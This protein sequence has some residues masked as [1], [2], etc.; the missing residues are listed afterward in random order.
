MKC[1][2]VLIRVSRPPQWNLDATTDLQHP[3]PVLEP[4]EEQPAHGMPFAPTSPVRTLLRTSDRVYSRT[5]RGTTSHLSELA[6]EFVKVPFDDYGAC[7]EFI[8]GHPEIRHESLDNFSEEAIR[9]QCDGKT[10]QLRNCVEKLLLLREISKMSDGD[11][12][13]FFSRMKVKDSTTRMG[14]VGDFNKV[15]NAVQAKAA[16]RQTNLTNPNGRRTEPEFVS[17]GDSR[18]NQVLAGIRYTPEQSRYTDFDDSLSAPMNRLSVSTTE[19]D[20]SWSYGAGGNNTRPPPATRH[21]TT[22]RRDTLSSVNDD[23]P[24]NLFTNNQPE[25]GPPSIVERTFDFRGTGGDREALDHRYYVRKDGA[26]FFT[27]GRVFAMLWHESARGE[28]VESKGKYGETVFSSILRLAVVKENHGFCLCIPIN[29]YNGQGV[30]KKGFNR[31]DQRAHAIIHMDDTAPGS[32]SKQEESLMTKTPIAVHPAATDQKLHIMSRLN[33][34]KI[35]SVQWNV[36][37]MN[38]GK[39]TEGS[40]GLFIGYWRNQLDQ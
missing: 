35:Y 38:V 22:G 18:Q 6:Q 5:T 11:C 12:R 32:T 16:G 21:S 39:V 8:D 13:V 2:E 27:I 15:I 17:S 30:L 40:M 34:A 10:S 24:L 25:G 7:Q 19:S 14:F 31:Q 28:N 33:F 37:V 9:L 36:K 4:R 3:K 20:S 23:S 1:V 29:T 26:K